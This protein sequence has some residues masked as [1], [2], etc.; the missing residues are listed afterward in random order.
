MNGN[1][2]VTANFAQVYSVTYS[3]NGGSGTLP[4]GNTY[5]QGA[6]VTVK[7]AALSQTGYVYVGWNSSADGTGT[8]YS[9]S[10]TMPAANVI[11]YAKWVV[12]D[13]DGNVYTSVKIGTQVWLAQNLRTTHYQNGEP[14]TLD[15]SS[16]AW[17]NDFA[18]AYCFYGNTTDLTQQQKFGA[19][20]NGYAVIDPKKIAPLGWHVPDST[21]WK[22]LK[23][24]LGNNAQKAL[25][26]QT[27]WATSTVVGSPGNVLSSNNS[28]NFTGLPAGDRSEYAAYGDKGTMCRWWSSSGD[29]NSSQGGIFD[30]E[31][32]YNGIYTDTWDLS[33]GFSVRLIHD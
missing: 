25:A 6:S 12:H 9:G 26:S 32:N 17:S 18:S 15:T 22:T 10:F 19:I 31:Y 11:L 30:L 14:I 13:N 28:T 16:D 24:Y 23:T 27:D 4:D 8:D 1:K 2:S 33:W 7:T 21:E 5:A 29:Y 20:Y 3:L